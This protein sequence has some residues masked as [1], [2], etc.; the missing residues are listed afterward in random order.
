MLLRSAAIPLRL[1]SN[2]EALV[3][4]GRTDRLHIFETL[5]PSHACV[6]HRCSFRATGSHAMHLYAFGNLPIPLA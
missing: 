5:V 3:A 4:T 6:G 2:C 1:T